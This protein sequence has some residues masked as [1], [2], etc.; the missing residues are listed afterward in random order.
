MPPV[1][2]SAKNIRGA[3]VGRGTRQKKHTRAHGKKGTNKE[4]TKRNTPKPARKNNAAFF[5]RTS[6]ELREKRKKRAKPPHLLEAGNDN[7]P[8]A[9]PEE[10]KKRTENEPRG[11]TESGQNC[12]R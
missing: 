8:R 1:Y 9:N 3:V 7:E 5:N 12:P 4:R 11:N 10:L 6:D 2:R